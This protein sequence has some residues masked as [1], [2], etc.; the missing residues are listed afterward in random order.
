MGEGV[1][2]PTRLMF[3][4]AYDWKQAGVMGRAL[5]QSDELCSSPVF[6]C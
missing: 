5:P 1:V 2:H 3:M 4:F 6:Q